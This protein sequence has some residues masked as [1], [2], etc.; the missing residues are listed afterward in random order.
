MHVGACPRAVACAAKPR[1]S[2][3]GQDASSVR[4]GDSPPSP[5]PCAQ[6][7]DGHRDAGS[8]SLSLSLRS[9]VLLGHCHWRGCWLAL[10]QRAGRCSQGRA[11]L[12][13]KKTG[14]AKGAGRAR[15]EAPQAAPG[16]GRTALAR[17]TGTGTCLWGTV[18]IPGGGLPPGRRS[19]GAQPTAADL[20]RGAWHLR[21]GW[22]P[23]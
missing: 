12:R 1:M 11:D 6:H 8:A 14:E 20:E 2:C 9:G 15:K 13:E 18:T 19:A 10:T 3:H 21:G 16:Q 23:R 4:E 22:L 17:S 7:R 5:E